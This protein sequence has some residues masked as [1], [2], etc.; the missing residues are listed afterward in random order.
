MKFPCKVKGKSNFY[1]ETKRCSRG[2]VGPDWGQRNCI[3]NIVDQDIYFYFSAPVPH[4]ETS[5]WSRGGLII[6]LYVILSYNLNSDCPPPHHENI[7]WSRGEKNN[8][9]YILLV[10][11]E[12]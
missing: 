11:F 8:W 9:Q 7:S 3:S 6:K 1:H 12:F 4:H 2:G 5:S 10:K